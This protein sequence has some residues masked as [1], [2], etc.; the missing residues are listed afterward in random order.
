MVVSSEDL[1]CL[2]LIIVRKQTLKRSFAQAWTKRIPPYSV[3]PIGFWC[4]SCRIAKYQTWISVI[5]TSNSWFNMQ[6]HST[7]Y[8][9][10]PRIKSI[11]I[12]FWPIHFLK[13]FSIWWSYLNPT[14]CV[15]ACALMYIIRAGYFIRRKPYLLR[16]CGIATSRTTIFERWAKPPIHVQSSLQLTI[17]LQPSLR[18]HPDV[19]LSVNR[20]QIT[21][22]PISNPLSVPNIQTDLLLSLPSVMHRSPVMCSRAKHFKAPVIPNDDK[23]TT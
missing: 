5:F 11:S 14:K 15:L 7:P 8:R 10:Y 9:D 12:T 22:T 20:Q 18:S 19:Y 17:P 3:S 1:A 23:R 4:D 21:L 16:L 2:D 13:A 6:H